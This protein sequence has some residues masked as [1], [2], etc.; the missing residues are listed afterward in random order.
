MSLMLLR[1]SGGMILD[2]TCRQRQRVLKS[3]LIGGI[4]VIKGVQLEHR[5][6]QT[7]VPMS[8]L[9]YLKDFFLHHKLMCQYSYEKKNVHPHQSW[10]HTIL[11]SSFYFQEQ[12]LY[13]FGHV[14]TTFFQRLLPLFLSLQLKFRVMVLYCSKTYGE[15]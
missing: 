14:I 4:P 12:L 6:Q 11:P 15:Q 5:F 2:S 3:L 8:W 7:D 13:V 10:N 9:L 1:L